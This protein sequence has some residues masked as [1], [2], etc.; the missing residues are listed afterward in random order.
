M[1][2]V[3]GGAF[4][5]VVGMSCV[6]RMGGAKLDAGFGSDFF[7]ICTGLTLMASRSGVLALSLVKVENSSARYYLALAAARLA[8]L[9]A[10]FEG[11]LLIF[12]RHAML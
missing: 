6:A 12:L 8:F 4:R 9:T 11:D 2:T 3:A 10:D 5:V 1:M 7:G